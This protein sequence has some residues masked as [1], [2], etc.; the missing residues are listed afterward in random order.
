VNHFIWGMVVLFITLAIVL[1]GTEWL[2][3]Q[4]KYQQGY[5]ACL[6]DFK[7]LEEH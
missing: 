6:T 4:E 7:I 1:L 5:K 2:E 3:Q